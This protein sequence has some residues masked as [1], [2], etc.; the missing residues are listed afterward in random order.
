MGVHFSSQ[1]CYIVYQRVIEKKTFGPWWSLARKKTAFPPT[2]HLLLPLKET[3]GALTWWR[4]RQVMALGGK[5]WLARKHLF[6]CQP[7]CLGYRDTFLFQFVP[8]ISL[9]IKNIETTPTGLSHDSH[10]LPMV[11][12]RKCFLVNTH[13]KTKMTLE[14]HHLQSEIHLQMVDFPLSC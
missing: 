2:P 10:V 12:L 9:Q 7:F 4:S 13:L 3:F 5:V 11:S 14:N 6:G 8:K 1:L